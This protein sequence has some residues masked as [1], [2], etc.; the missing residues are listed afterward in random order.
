MFG[1]EKTEY[2]KSS[3]NPGIKAVTEKFEPVLKT[4]GAASRK[5]QELYGASADIY[6]GSKY[7]K[8]DSSLM[9]NGADWK[10]P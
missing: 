7:K 4:K 8:K 5:D 6:G 1:G 9:A 10:N 3:Q 2:A